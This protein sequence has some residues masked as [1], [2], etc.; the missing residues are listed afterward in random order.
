M[1]TA[2]AEPKASRRGEVVI[3]LIGLAGV[4]TTGVLSNWDKLFPRQNVVQATYSGYRPT[5]SFETEFRYYFDVSGT[6]QA[7]ESMQRQLLLNAKNA[8]LAQEPAKAKKI[9]EMFAVID[10]ESIKIDDVIRE[11]LPIYQKHFTLAEIQELNK[12]YS[13]EVMQTMVKKMPLI[14]QDAAP[15]QIKMMQDYMQRVG[16][17]LREVESRP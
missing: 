6:R 16:A 15:I 8:A 4:L 2:A 17:R 7:I 1:T 10:K 13:T 3:A 5:G 11:V 14:T 12:F 9:D